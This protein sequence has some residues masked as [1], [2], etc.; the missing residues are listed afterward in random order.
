MRVVTVI[1]LTVTLV[2]AFTAVAKAAFVSPSS[3][4]RMIKN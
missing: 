1:L 2:A 3:I 4:E